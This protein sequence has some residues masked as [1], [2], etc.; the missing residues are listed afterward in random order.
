[1][2]DISIGAQIRGATALL[3]TFESMREAATEAKWVV[4]TNVEYSVYVEFGTSRMAA[5]PY[6]RPAVESARRKSERIFSQADSISGYVRDLA[7]FIEADA[8]RR[9]PV[10]TGNLRASIRAEKV[11]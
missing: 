1:M 4:G 5:Q 6:L 9:C 10:D 11:N 3:S 8:K 7:L 2:A